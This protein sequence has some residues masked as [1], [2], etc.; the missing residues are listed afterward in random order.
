MLQS[1]IQIVVVVGVASW[2]D[3][4]VLGA[5]RQ[6]SVKQSVSDVVTRVDQE[7]GYSIDPDAVAQDPA[8]AKA[9][10]ERKKGSDDFSSQT[11]TAIEKPASQ[12]IPAVDVEQ[13]SAQNDHYVQAL[14]ADR[15]VAALTVNS[16]T[17][18]VEETPSLTLAAHGVT[19]HEHKF[20]GT[21]QEVRFIKAE[22]LFIRVKPNRYSKSLGIV[23]GGDEVRV[24]IQGDWA[25]L[26][27]GQYIRS[28]WLVK[29][30]PTTYGVEDAQDR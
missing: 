9:Y 7:I 23:R 26:D 11:V 3:S 10:L 16:K 12:A 15:P 21:G 14:S 17:K 28:R 2:I 6:Q 27:D 19:S 29:H 25:K 22:Q 13:P 20:I 30:K 18:Q 8:D 5:V 24:T 1:I 4:S